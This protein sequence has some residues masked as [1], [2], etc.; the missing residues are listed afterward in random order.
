MRKYTKPISPLA[1]L[2]CLRAL[3]GLSGY[4]RHAST[5]AMGQFAMIY[6]AFRRSV[7]WAS[8]PASAVPDRPQPSYRN[9]S[10]QGISDES[11]TPERS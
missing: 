6:F 11:F 2:A 9:V 3:C 4:S 7:P 8:F 5:F 1:Y 10:S